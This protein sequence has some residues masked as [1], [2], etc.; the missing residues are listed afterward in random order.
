MLSAM[1]SYTRKLA[2]RHRHLAI[3]AVGLACAY[4]SGCTVLNPNVPSPELEQPDAYLTKNG[5]QWRPAASPY[6]FAS[7]K[8]K[9]L[10]DLVALGRG[11]NLD[12]AAAIARIQQAEAFVRVA[13]QPLI[14]SIQAQGSA[15]QSLTNINGTA[16]RSPQVTGEL[17]ASYQLDFWGQNRAALYSAIASQYSASFASATIAI[18][19][20]ASVATAYFDVIGTQKQ[21]DIA[22]QNLVIARRTL[23]AIRDRF[24]AGTASGL[25]VAQQET[26]VANVEVTIPPLESQREQFKHA[27]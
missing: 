13:T 19:T 24:K 17:F 9:R 16:V 27:L 20:D 4:L 1:A 2:S 23:D 25:D 12:I 10:T 8:S 26:L 3:L 15:S 7:F 5:K 11:F 6:D 18:T 21:I 22:K 14:P